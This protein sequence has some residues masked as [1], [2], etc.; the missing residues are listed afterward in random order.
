MIDAG[1]YQAGVGAALLGERAGALDILNGAD[2]AARLALLACA[3]MLREPL[4]IEK[5]GGL[6]K[7]PDKLLALAAVDGNPG[8]PLR[9]LGHVG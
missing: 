2:R 8:N 7:S 4:P 5:V 6:L 9:E 1:G 3:R